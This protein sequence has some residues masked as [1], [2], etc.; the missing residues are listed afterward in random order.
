MESIVR[1]S[2][3]ASWDPKSSGNI[4][5][6]VSAAA[7][8]A[9][10]EPAGTHSLLRE[11]L[12]EAMQR[13]VLAQQ[14]PDLLSSAVAFDASAF[15]ALVALGELGSRADGLTG[16]LRLRWRSLLTRLDHGIESAA[17]IDGMQL[18]DL[19]DVQ[20][21]M[22]S[23]GITPKVSTEFA[24][25]F[26]LSER[27]DGGFGTAAAAPVAD[28]QVTY[29]A[30]DLAR[31]A[32]LRLPGIARLRATEVSQRSSDGGWRPPGEPTGSPTSTREALAIA[33]AEHANARQP[34]RDDGLLPWL[35]FL[36]SEGS[37]P[38]DAMNASL[39]AQADYS[40]VRSAQ[41]GG[42]AD[43]TIRAS[44]KSASLAGAHPVISPTPEGLN[45]LFYILAFDSVAGVPSTFS[46]SQLAGWLQQF[47][48]HVPMTLLAPRYLLELGSISKLAGSN[49]A[50]ATETRVLGL[51]AREKAPSGGYAY[52]NATLMEP[53]LMSTRAAV[54]LF[55]LYQVP[56][57]NADRLKRLS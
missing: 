36:K 31:T 1:P 39:R 5:A 51:L 35:Q 11:R 55:T 2:G 8:F 6:S 56:V 20:R 34:Q 22:K 17:V 37:L 57:P 28:P 29:D 46:A 21:A 15:K 53:D 33:V 38:R 14:R 50:S 42:V 47:E 43:S 44:S 52:N 41:L 4:D 54:A 23:L 25:R 32:T 24:S 9:Y 49:V 19:L 27:S 7:A 40:I 13:V 12:S 30:L 26:V 3:F 48:S 10:G 18:P 45:E 16:T